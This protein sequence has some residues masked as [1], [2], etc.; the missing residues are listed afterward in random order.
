MTA[1][2]SSFPVLETAKQKAIRLRTEGH[3]LRVVVNEVKTP[4]S[5]V[6]GWVRHI[7]PISLIESELAK[8]FRE[9]AG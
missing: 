9:R 4:K 7:K 6:Y 1:D 8:G 5:T 3:S 2:A